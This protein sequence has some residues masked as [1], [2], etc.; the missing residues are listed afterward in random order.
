M[1]N[2]RRHNRSTERTAQY[3]G[4][5]YRIVCT[6]KAGPE[7]PIKGARNHDEHS[8]PSCFQDPSDPLPRPVRSLPLVPPGPG[9]GPGS[10]EG[11]G[12]GPPDAVSK[13][14]KSA[15]SCSPGSLQC[16]ACFSRLRKQDPVQCRTMTR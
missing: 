5:A 3:K 6:S 15:A 16:D 7:R 12:P 10:L 8:V 9:T 14:S 13:R 4:R 11:S 2:R 1:K